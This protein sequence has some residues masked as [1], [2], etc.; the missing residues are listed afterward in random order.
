MSGIRWTERG[1]RVAGQTLPL[2]VIFMMSLLLAAGMAIDIGNAYRVK[3]SLQASAA[4]RRRRGRATCRARA[5]RSRPR[6]R[7]A[8]SRVART[9]SPGSGPVSL[10]AAANCATGPE[11]CTPANTVQVTESADVPTYFLHLVG[12][13]DI[14]VTVHSQACSPC[15]ALPLDIVMVLDRTGSMSGQKLTNA[16]QGVTS[17]L[18]D[19]DPAIDDVGLVV[20]PPAA[21]LGAKCGSAPSSNYNL[22]NAAYLVVPLSNDYAGSQGN[23]NGSSDL[24]STLNCVQAGGQTAYANALDAAQAELDANGR[25]GVQKVIIFLSDGA[26]NSGPGYL[27]AT[28]PYRTQPCH[29][30]IQIAAASKA[31]K[32]LVYSIAYDL[33]VSGAEACQS[34]LGG[35]ESPRILAN[36]AMQQIATPG[37]YYYQPQ[38]TQLVGVFDAITADLAKGTSRING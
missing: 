20:L 1:G 10:Q 3:Q 2:V 24:I 19:L 36:Q 16:K 30:A 7:S 32:V 33:D 38:P 22:T 27:P 18:D 25:P 21:S 37:N 15:G 31:S 17:F 9:R 13:N 5:P 35:D 11:F 29:T 6:T 8:R 4:P 14:T 28:S 34:A 12:I 23:L 26:A